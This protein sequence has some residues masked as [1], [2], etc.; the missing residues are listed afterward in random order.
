MLG[1]GLDFAIRTTIE[2]HLFQDSQQVA[3]D[4]IG[5]RPGSSPQLTPK[6]SINLLQFADSHGQVLAASP[7]AAGRA[8][9]STMRPPI[10]DRIEHGTECSPHRGCVVLTAVRIPPLQTREIWQGEP[11]Y[12]YAGL[13]QPP[14]LARHRLQFFTAAGIALTAAL[15]AWGTWWGVGRTLRPVRAIR[16]RMAEI[17]VSDLSLRV[18][19]PPGVDEIAQL[20]RT[21]NQTLA[22]LEESVE[23]QRHFASVVSH[24]LRNPVAGLHTLLEEA[25]LYPDDVDPRKTIQ[26]SLSTT[27]RFRSIIDDVLVLARIRTT[28]P[29]APEP[30]DLGALVKEEV[31]GR[32]HGVPVR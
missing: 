1:A 14:I 10:Y 28:A 2:G 16:A 7:E 3:T 22:R 18:P 15:A 6:T 21:A 26:A 32:A 13:A 29:A 23:S 24:E 11:H 27:E 8:P 5:W 20:A 31:A 12:V 25:L 9:L 30:I 17:T 4:L 19:T